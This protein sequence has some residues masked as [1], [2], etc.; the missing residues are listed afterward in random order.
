MCRFQITH[1]LDSF[2]KGLIE[3]GNS[4]IVKTAE[5]G[6]DGKGQ[7]RLKHFLKNRYL[8]HGRN[9]KEDGL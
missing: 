4:V 8:K 1:D 7:L 2:A 9:L 6:Y 3:I 5:F